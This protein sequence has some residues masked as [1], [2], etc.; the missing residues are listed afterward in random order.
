ME[1]TY[2]CVSIA[3]SLV[4][5]GLMIAPGGCGD[6]REELWRL[7]IKGCCSS[8][9]SSTPLGF[10]SAGRGGRVEKAANPECPIPGLKNKQTNKHKNRFSLTLR[11]EEKCVPAAPS[12]VRT[13]VGRLQS[14]GER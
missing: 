11:E 10:R 1:I 6:H 3:N 14:W 5:P 8:S 2:S 9:S 4:P 13:R 7:T 12:S